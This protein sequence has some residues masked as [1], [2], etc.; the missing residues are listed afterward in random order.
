[1]RLGRPGGE[2]RARRALPEDWDSV[3]WLREQFEQGALPRESE[4]VVRSS[5]GGKALEP[6]EEM[7]IRRGEHELDEHAGGGGG[8]G[9]LL[10]MGAGVRPRGP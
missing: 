4:L 5:H 6:A 10:G 2:A 8:G 3:F 9:G 1:M 7:G